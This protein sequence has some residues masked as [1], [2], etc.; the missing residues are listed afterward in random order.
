MRIDHREKD[1][2][3]HDRGLD[4]DL[5]RLLGRRGL[6]KLVARAG[7]AGASLITLGACA[8][9]TSTADTGPAQ[10]GMPPRGGPGGGAPQPTQPSDTANGEIP[11]ETSGPYP[12]D[13]SNGANVLTQ[14]G[15]VRRDITSS[16]GSSTTKADGVPL[17]ITMTVNDFANNKSLLA[18]AAV[19]LWHCDREGRYSL[20]SQDIT[21]ENYLRGVQETDDRGQVKFD[22]IFPACYSGR[23]PHIH[24][25]VYP[26]LTKATNGSNK[27]ATSQIALLADT[28]NAVYA[29]S[30]YEQS[31]SNLSRVS[32]DSD[33]VF[34]DGYDLQLPTITG[35]PSRGYS[36]AFDC[37]V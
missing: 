22:T 3:N 4:Y 2:E 16:F 5:P 35:D 6:L 26:S 11:E 25:E 10:G 15:I 37:A 8:D 36:L 1:L 19:Y 28:C 20:Y 18:G 7:L 21:N 30:G 17:G 27:I 34:G 32:L 14:S 24:F 12:G 23:W 29:T 9:A 33:N 31:A 13:G